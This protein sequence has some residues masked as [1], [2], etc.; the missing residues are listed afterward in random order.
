MLKVYDDLFAADFIMRSSQLAHRIPWTYTNVANRKQFPFD[1][2]LT[3]G[4]HKFFG[5]NLYERE[6]HRLINET[7][8]EFFQVLDFVCTDYIEE[9]LSLHSISSNLQVY[10]QDGTAHKDIYVGD[11][12]DRTILFF[13]HHEWKE[14]WGGALEILNE[15]KEVIESILPMP[16][17]IVYLDSNVLHR[18]RA[19][20][21][22]NIARMSIAYRMKVI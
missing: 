6:G 9:K 14:E 5:A 11:S 12:K 18:A 21:V 4:S 7:P 16:G 22:K 17:R 3:K 13:C 8:D 1:S 20:L 10:G 19:P 2:V 15:D